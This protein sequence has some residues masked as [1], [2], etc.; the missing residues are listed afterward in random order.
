MK[1]IQIADEEEEAA[2]QNDTGDENGSEEEVQPY[3]FD[4][5][6]FAGNQ[7]YEGEY[8]GEDEDEGEDEG[9]SHQ[10]DGEGEDEGEDEG[11]SHQSD[12]FVNSH[13]GHVQLENNPQE[14]SLSPLSDDY[15][16]NQYNSGDVFGGPET[17]SISGHG[18]DI[19][20]KPSSSCSSDSSDSVSLAA[21][22]TTFEDGA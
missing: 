13:G 2:N 19:S 14:G 4:Q 1:L 9:T 7:V 20:F 11:S 3:T 16:A 8:E 15:R 6:M 21:T 10:S 5:V 18:S 22:E 17:P 12:V